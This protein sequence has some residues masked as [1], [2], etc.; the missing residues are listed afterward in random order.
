[1]KE[2]CSRSWGLV[3]KSAR[4][5]MIVTLQLVAAVAVFLLAVMD[6]NVDVDVV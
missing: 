2:C 1:M 3:S 5:V 4:A 6:V